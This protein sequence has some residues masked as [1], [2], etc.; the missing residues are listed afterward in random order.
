MGAVQMT[1]CPVDGC[2]TIIVGGSRRD[3]VK[4]WDREC[5]PLARLYEPG[6]GVIYLG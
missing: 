1:E 4:H 3:W 6:P 2:D 5:N